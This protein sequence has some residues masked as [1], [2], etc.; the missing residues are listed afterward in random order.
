MILSLE[1]LFKELV[2]SQ[3]QC[4]R[5]ERHKKDY[6]EKE[7]KSSVTNFWILLVIVAP[8]ITVEG[9]LQNVIYITYT[10]CDN[11]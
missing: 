7:M 11:V 1:R 8:S 9:M 5:I 2:L 4:E 6:R 10:T 3:V